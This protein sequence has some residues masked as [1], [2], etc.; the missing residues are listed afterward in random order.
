[1]PFFEVRYT[2]DWDDI[3]EADDQF[4]AEE[5]FKERNSDRCIAEEVEGMTFSQY[6][7]KRTKLP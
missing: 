6:I 1:M 2:G 5:K 7:K 4:G 3:I